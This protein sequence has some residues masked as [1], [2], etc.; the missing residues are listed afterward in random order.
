MGAVGVAHSSSPKIEEFW[1]TGD[2]SVFDR[3]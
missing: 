1:N 3:S 2:P